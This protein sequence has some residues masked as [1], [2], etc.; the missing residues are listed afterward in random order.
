MASSYS[1]EIPKLSNIGV[2]FLWTHRFC[3][4][5]TNKSAS[6]YCHI[7]HSRERC[8]CGLPHR[9]RS[10]RQIHC[11]TCLPNRYVK[12]R[13]RWQRRALQGCLNPLRRWSYHSS[14]WSRH[15]LPGLKGPEVQ[16]SLQHKL[17]AHSLVCS[18]CFPLTDFR[19]FIVELR[20]HNCT[21]CRFILK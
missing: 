4:T 13:S 17:P 2:I 11:A 19:N 16:V 12:V 10:T 6:S 7:R 21:T 5:L 3:R 14:E 8:R 18:S 20:H 9:R 15:E 1:E